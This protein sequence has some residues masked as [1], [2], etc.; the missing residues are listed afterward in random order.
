MK[1]EASLDNIYETF[2]LKHRHRACAGTPRFGEHNG[3][4]V[5]VHKHMPVR[6][7]PV[8]ARPHVES[9]HETT[10]CPTSV[11][12][13]D[14]I[15]TNRS[16]S[17]LQ[18]TPLDHERG[19]VVWVHTPLMWLHECSDESISTPDASGPSRVC[20]SSRPES[21]NDSHAIRVAT[22]VYIWP[23]VTRACSKCARLRNANAARRTG[24][25]GY[26]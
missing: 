9:A 19:L 12:G 26:A 23:A 11:D 25:S 18:A 16:T 2:V 17:C 5:L 8:C 21:C 13:N 14:E 15:D 20:L 4:G 3:N 6:Q 22:C 10:T 24:R 1:T 7:I